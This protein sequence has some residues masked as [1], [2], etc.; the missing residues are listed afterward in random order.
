MIT[1]EV[2]TKEGK[3]ILS[4]LDL[5]NT[6][7]GSLNKKDR[8]DQETLAKISVELFQEQKL[9][10]SLS[11]EELAMLVFQL[12]YF[13]RIFLEKN[14]VKIQNNEPALNHTES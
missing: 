6:L 11:P 7:L 12:G 1:W 5:V 13:Y 2:E 8:K 14:E 9:L 10:N 4:P 3:L